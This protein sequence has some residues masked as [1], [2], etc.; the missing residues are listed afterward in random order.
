VA[1]CNNRPAPPDWPYELQGFFDPYRIERAAALLSRP[2]LLTP[3]DMATFQLDLQSELARRWKSLAAA[4]ATRAGHEETATALQQWDGIMDESDTLATVFSLW[5][6][7]LT[8]ALFEDDLGPGGLRGALDL[9]QVVLEDTIAGLI[10]DQRTAAIET[11][12][13]IAARAMEEALRGAAGRPWGVAHT[14]TVRHPLA[15]VAAI[16]R[17]LNLTRGPL[18]WAGDASTLSAS[19]SILDRDRSTF[20]V[21][22]GPSMRF[23][24]DWSDPDAFTLTPALGQSGH[25]HSPHF[26]DFLEWSRTGRR[27]VVPLTRAAAD[28]RRVS[29]V[30][31]IPA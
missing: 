30:R 3:A 19:F 27:W 22:T 10:D 24:M 6:H 14:L 17:L 25:P 8:P 29:V 31:L 7:A 20:A 16:D 4:G 15:R 11:T 2:G 9:Q 21:A 18:P 1:S 13:D 23:V 5:W 26:A 28:A 12:E